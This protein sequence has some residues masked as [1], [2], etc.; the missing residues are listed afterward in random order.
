MTNTNYYIQLFAKNKP[1]F[2]NISSNFLDF[3]KLSNNTNNT[4]LL[5]DFNSINP[6][7]AK[8]NIKN[9]IKLK[10]KTN[11]GIWDEK[12]NKYII[13]KAYNYD[14]NNYFHKFLISS[15]YAI[16]KN[17]K[18]EM[19]DY[20]YNEVCNYLDQKF[21]DENLC[22]FKNNKCGEKRNTICTVGCCRHYKHKILGPLPFNKFIICEHLKNKRC[23]AKCI[24]CKLFT[25]DYL[26]KKGIKFK[27][28]EI[29][30]LDTFFNPI[31]KFIIKTSVYTKKEAIIQKLLFWSF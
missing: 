25:C 19:Y 27:I 12:S 2:E 26:N 23:S 20:I 30:L 18:K 21:I 11:I 28:K 10:K 14:S 3:N 17:N 7:L 16:F 1:N 29:F 15:I 9:L 24:S 31:Q 6:I 22:D 4:F 5:I 8:K 13:A